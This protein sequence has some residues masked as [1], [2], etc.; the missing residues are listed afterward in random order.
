MRLRILPCFDLCGRADYGPPRN[1]ANAMSSVWQRLADIVGSV[2]AR[3]GVAGSLANLL[4]PD[5]WLPGGRDA[6]FTL[7]LIALSAKMAVADGV[8][9]ASELRAFKRTVEI[10]S[11]IEAQ[12]DRVYA[13]ARQDVA[14]F[15]AYAKKIARFFAREPETLEHVLDG[16]F[17]IAS[18]DGYVHEAELAYLQQVSGIFGFDEARFEQIAA[19][20]VEL[21]T[22]VDPYVVLGLTPNADR[23]EVRRVYRLLVAEHHPDRLIAKGV[24]E[25]LIDVAT[26]RMQAINAAYSRIVRL[27]PPATAA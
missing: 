14:G 12:V 23:A 20:H 17:F 2:G 11:G 7:A 10:P 13:L 16:L 21:D 18:A 22:S 26:A 25:E 9:T 15:E 5:T 3:T 8:A 4:D 27:P 24:P 19:Q 6:A 1:G